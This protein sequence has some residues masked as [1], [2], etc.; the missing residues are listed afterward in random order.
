MTRRCQNIFLFKT[1]RAVYLSWDTNCHFLLFSHTNL[2]LH[3]AIVLNAPFVPLHISICTWNIWYQITM[4]HTLWLSLKKR[5]LIF[6]WGPLRQLYTFYLEYIFS[7]WQIQKTVFRSGPVH[8]GQ[9]RPFSI[10][11]VIGHIF[12]IVTVLS[13]QSPDVDLNLSQLTH[14]RQKFHSIPQVHFT[15]IPWFG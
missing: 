3:N 4:K 6:I 2:Q 15:S 1:M 11:K 13:L 5:C 8:F 7:G 12:A 10:F 9:P 14:I